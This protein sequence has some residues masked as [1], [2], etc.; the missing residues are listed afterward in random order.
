MVQLAIGHRGRTSLV[1]FSGR[2]KHTDQ[3][4]M[5]N[6]KLL[7]YASELGEVWPFQQG[8]TSI[9]T[10]IEDKNQFTANNVQVLP[11]LVKSFDLNIV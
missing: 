10:T 8:G 1:F 9:H 2:Q 4:Q 7:S 11:W 5:L 3:I 6:S